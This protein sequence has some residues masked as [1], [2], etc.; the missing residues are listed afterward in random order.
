MRRWL[1]LACIL[2]FALVLHLYRLSVLP[3]GLY[4]DEMDTGYQ[5]FSLLHTGRDY[6]GN[7]F[8]AHLQS[9]ADYRSSL[10]ML[11]TVPL[12]KFFGITAI[13][14]R[15]ISV[16]S[17]LFS[18][19]AIYYLAKRFLNFGRYAWIPAAVF[20]FAPWG[21]IQGR[22]AAESGLMLCLFLLGTSL[23]Y[24]KSYKL[25]AISYSLT[26]W[27]YGT[28]KLFFPL[29]LIL[30]I[31]INYKSFKILPKNFLVPA[32]LFVLVA[33]MPVY[34]TFSKPVG[35]RFT[36]TSVFSDPTIA[37]QVNYQRLNLALALG[38]P[39][40]LGMQPSIIEKL[41]YNRPML[42]AK[43]I[44]SN[45]FQSLSSDFLFRIGDPNLRHHI[46]LM[47]TGQFVLIDI[48]PFLLGLLI[49]LK[50]Y[51]INH[52]SRLLLW[53]FLI[54]PLPSILTGDGGNHAP[55]LLFLFP[56]V[57]F[58]V[59]LGLKKIFSYKPYAISYLLIFIPSL[60]L[61][62]FYFFTQYRTASAS[63]F[64]TNFIPAVNQ[65]I[66]A[67]HDYDYV[68]LDMGNE[69]ALMAYLVAS[70]YPPQEFQ[71][72]FPLPSK[73]LLPGLEGYLFD[74][75]VILY[76]GTRSWANLDLPGTNLVISV[77]SPDTRITAFEK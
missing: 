64:N 8:S 57:V 24:S 77:T 73:S 38:R 31:I 59:S 71:K 17:F 28:A 4:W 13:S 21:L 46:N 30:L 43:K 52:K 23:F 74:N 70:G 32:L 18:V 53:W 48:V 62:I 58:I 7:I 60:F 19:F 10:Y 36:E 76:P 26:L 20:A 40:T 22:I 49:L 75:I 34:E 39:Q 66:Q 72:S 16:V 2:V 51:F 11:F 3:S 68:V 6:F 67:K 41:V 45:Y 44:I 50:S 1:P 54:A 9:F 5:S 56:A 15:L 47:N 42:I 33:F 65:A 55:R 29:F 12:V 14:I 25:S 63:F 61:T 37:S 35:R 69:S 27:S